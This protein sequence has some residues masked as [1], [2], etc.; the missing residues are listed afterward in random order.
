MAVRP[1]C[2]HAEFFCLAPYVGEG[3]RCDDG[4]RRKRVGMPVSGSDGLERWLET[5]GGGS[6][7][8]WNCVHGILLSE[9][10][11]CDSTC[12]NRLLDDVTE[13]GFLNCCPRST[14]IFR[15]AGSKQVLS[16]LSKLCRRL[17]MPAQMSLIRYYLTDSRYFD[18]KI[19]LLEMRK[20]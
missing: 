20:W 12:L 14:S 18:N 1:D 13:G 10:N 3:G 19:T 15:G 9:M 4:H 17:L 5:S 6:H 11:G 8:G 7:C 16:R 2:G